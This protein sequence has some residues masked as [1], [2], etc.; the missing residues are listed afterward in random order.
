LINKLFQLRL[1]LHA[2]WG[3]EI[4]AQAAHLFIR[5]LVEAVVV[6]SNHSQ[7]E[8][9]ALSRQFV[10]SLV[11]QR[12]GAMSLDPILGSWASTAFGYRDH[13]QSKLCQHIA[14]PL[15]ESV[16]STVEIGSRNA[17]ALING[18]S[19]GIREMMLADYI[20]EIVLAVAPVTS[21]CS[22]LS[23]CWQCAP[24]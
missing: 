17:I 9:R 5:L 8:V 11:E 23:Q 6:G 7:E 16:F 21:V 14:A 12:Y 2:S 20:E 4:Q 24:Y 15:K 10:C 3:N 13:D 19:P 1:P 22:F 18:I